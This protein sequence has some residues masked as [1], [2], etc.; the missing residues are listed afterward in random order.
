MPDYSFNGGQART[1]ADDPAARAERVL[2][3]VAETLERL[4]QQA[5]EHQ[6]WLNDPARRERA[7]LAQEYINET[8]RR[9]GGA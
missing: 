8:R 7:E 1:E 3:T 4:E 5:A 6:R 2:A 9:N